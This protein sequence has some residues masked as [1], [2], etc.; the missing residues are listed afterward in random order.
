MSGIIQISTSMHG[1]FSLFNSL[2]SELSSCTPVNYRRYRFFGN[3]VLDRFLASDIGE[4]RI[5]QGMKNRTIC[6]ICIRHASRT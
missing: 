3:A 4:I 5:F 6:V 2:K 1:R